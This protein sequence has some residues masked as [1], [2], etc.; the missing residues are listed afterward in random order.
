MRTLKFTIPALIVAISLL[1]I[2]GGI[3]G[4]TQATSS[5]FVNH[6][7]V[8][9]AKIPPSSSTA[10]DEQWVEND[11]VPPTQS[12]LLI[13]N[14]PYLDEQWALSQIQMPKLWQITTGNSEILV[15][16]L[17][18]GIDQNHEDLK[19]KVVA[20]VNFT[21]SLTPSDIYGHGTHIAGIIAANGNNGV[22]IV[23]MAPQTQLMNAKIAND[24]GRCQAAAL[25]KGI[26]WAVNN[27]ANVINISVELEEPSPELEGAVNF[28]WSQGV[29]IVAAAG[30][31]SSQSPVYPAYYENCI[32]VAATKQ[33][34]TL[35]PLSNYGDWVDVAAPGF[36]IY[37]T[38]PDNVYGYK[39]GTSF[40]SAY[41][42]GLAALLFSVVTDTNGDSR[43]NDEVR[44][45]IEDG[46]QQASM[47]SV[48]CGRIDAATA[49][50]KTGY[51][52]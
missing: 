13:P 22:G 37:S 12:E 49:L 39:S 8:A 46:C 2:S 34:D 24:K 28:A 45:A 23:G 32:A 50:A 47:N 26:I 16:V 36:N 4:D 14:D 19:G 15:A 40:A 52:P 35:A 21:D 5:S 3:I 51:I 29:V 33:D 41:V 1:I 44:A 17:D 30:N 18:T 20:E 48:G 42:S 10:S 31:E 7:P 9:Q 25:A 6:T 38:L 27:G 43:L 11:S